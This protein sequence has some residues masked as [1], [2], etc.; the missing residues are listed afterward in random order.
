MIRRISWEPGE[1]KVFFK[2][3]G[4][5]SG[6]DPHVFVSS[7]KVRIR[8]ST[9][10][11]EPSVVTVTVRK[12]EGANAN[13]CR[14]VKN[15]SLARYFGEDAPVRA[16]YDLDIA[17]NINELIKRFPS[18]VY[19]RFA[20]RTLAYM[21]LH[22]I[23]EEQK[24]E[25]ALQLLR[26]FRAME[27]S[28]LWKAR[29]QYW[30]G[31][32]CQLAGRLNEA[33]AA[34]EKVLAMPKVD[35]YTQARTRER[36]AK[37][38]REKGQSNRGSEVAPEKGARLTSELRRSIRRFVD[39]VETAVESNDK[40]KYRDVVATTRP[41]SR[42]LSLDEED[43]PEGWTRE[44]V[45]AKEW[46]VGE[47]LVEEFGRAIEDEGRI[48]SWQIDIKNI[49]LTNEGREARVESVVTY[50]TENGKRSSAEV[51]YMLAKVDGQWRLVGH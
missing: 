11:A 18:T 43:L 19:A 33:K 9:E 29:A 2:E 20:R 6:G 31:H 15:K 26:K 49:R 10:G 42:R 17:N 7:G 25:K 32:G 3:I 30:L 37:V 51:W 50:R 13:A 24:P 1:A 34:Y 46:R 23:Q 45:Q 48:A 36:L 14:F 16:E 44:D 4:V 39:Q 38:L 40:G 21:W 12:P 5:P 22:G 47:Q 27:L 8:F 41:E 35:A 28:P